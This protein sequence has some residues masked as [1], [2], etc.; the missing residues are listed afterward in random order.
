VY[1]EAAKMKEE[2]PT[3]FS[4][5]ELFLECNNNNNNN[6]NNNIKYIALT[7]IVRLTYIKV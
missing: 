5:T 2:L 3:L 1:E 4:T 7:A 6:N